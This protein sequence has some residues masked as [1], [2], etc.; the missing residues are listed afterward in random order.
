MLKLFVLLTAVVC[1]NACRFIK[2]NK[3]HPG[4]S[5]SDGI[6]HEFRSVWE[7]GSE[8][9]LCLVNTI[10]CCEKFG[11]NFAAH[12]PEDTIVPLIPE[13]TPGIIADYIGAITENDVGETEEP[14]Q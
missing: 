8:T 14:M 2:L 10:I 1:C 7:K 12:I 5:D 4:C 9:C 3:Q 11:S 6:H 13:S